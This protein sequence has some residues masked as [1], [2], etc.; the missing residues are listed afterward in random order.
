MVPRTWGYNKTIKGRCTENGIS[1]RL[2]PSI[3]ADILGK[4]NK[5]D[6]IEI[7]DKTDIKLQVEEAYNYWYKIKLSNG[8][9][10]WVFGEY[11]KER[12]FK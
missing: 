6:E 5:Y 12:G 8:T 3:K 11:V 1:I 4:L 10:G 2:R 7:I 9:M